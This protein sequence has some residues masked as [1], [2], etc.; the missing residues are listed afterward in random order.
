MT[1]FRLFVFTA[2]MVAATAV[3]APAQ[4]T[5]MS[6]RPESKVVLA[7]GSNVHDW[8]CNSSAFDAAITMD[9]SYGSPFTSVARPITSVVV[10]IPVKSLKCGKGKMDDNMYK[11]LKADQ[12]TEIKYVLDTYEVNREGTT[13]DAF[14]ARTTGDL[15]V[16]G[17][18]KK[19][20]IPI[21]ADRLPNGGMKGVGTAKLLMT[22]FGIKPPVALLGTLRTKNEIE[23]TF[24]VLLD[25]STV[26][27]I[28]ER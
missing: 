19:V 14:V 22:D 7:G 9:D 2:A 1:R 27:A 11:A 13:A 15:T 24:T 12:F 17:V 25:K 10:T 23:I 4:G 8:A 26:V 28:T 16:A 21:T 6:L 18:T 20:E 5:R 3:P